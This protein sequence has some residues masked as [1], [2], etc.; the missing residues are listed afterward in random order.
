M[1]LW[2]LFHHCPTLERRGKRKTDG[3]RLIISAR[4][5]CAC[6]S[7]YLYNISLILFRMSYFLVGKE[8][9]GLSL[10]SIN[11]RTYEL[12]HPPT[13]V[14]GVGVDGTPHFDFVQLE[15]SEINLLCLDSPEFPSTR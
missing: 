12:A 14:Q 4:I 10:S 3:K 1:A 8:R 9:L 7:I 6:L 2:L 13:G 15:H 11:P 5:T